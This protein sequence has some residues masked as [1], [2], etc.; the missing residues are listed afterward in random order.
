MQPTA[1][2]QVQFLLDVGRLLQDGSF[3]ATYKHALLLSIA[4]VCVENVDDSGGKFRISIDDL[5]EKFISYYWRQAI[6]YQPLGQQQ[7]GAVLKQNTAKQATIIT[8]IVRARAEY[9]G[10][11][12]RLKA[13]SWAWRSLRSKVANTIREMPLWRLQTI[14]RQNLEFLYTQDHGQRE[15]IELKEGV[16]FCFR[17]FHGL[18]HE[19]VRG[20]WLRFVRS[21]KEN[22][23]LLGTAT[24]ISDFMFGSSRA[25]LEVYRPILA[26]YQNGECFYC[27]KVLRDKVDVDHFI[28]W[29]RY[30]VDLGHNFV[31][32][33]QTCNG[34]KGDRLAAAN[35]LERWCKRSVD[36]GAELAGRFQEKNIIHDQQASRQITLWAYEQAQHTN[37]DVWL[38]GKSL[39]ALSSSWRSSLEGGC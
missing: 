37:S 9:A 26:E 17:L 3:V 13:D 31:L 33:H 15:S 25:P 38:I 12:V 4:D 11:L 36:H 28:P 18:I 22:R 34:Q 30:P 21:I 14:G 20:A 2:K 24:D 29:S 39:I 19:L 7:P 1:K 35:H 8:S 6:P 16:C 10:S 32:S 5:A 23:T 27:L